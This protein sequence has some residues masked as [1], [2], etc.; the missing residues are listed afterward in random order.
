MIKSPLYSWLVQSL[1]DWLRISLPEGF[2][3]R[4]EQPL[5]LP[6][7]EPEPDIAVVKGTGD[8]YRQA[9][10]Q[11]AQ[12][13]IE[14]AVGSA[15]LDRE[16]AELYAAADVVEY[17]VVLPDEKTVEVHTG[18][19]PSGYSNRES[20]AKDHVLSLTCLPKLAL[21]LRRLFS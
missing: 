18:P 14:V 4:Q 7:S 17:W 2:H 6:H 12:L 21:D 5:T 16:K 11:T 20:R 9:H 19:T 13:V 15:A 1:A 10:P 8:D 3:V